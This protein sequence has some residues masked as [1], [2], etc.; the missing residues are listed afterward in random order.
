LLLS[1]I[2]SVNDDKKRAFWLNFVMFNDRPETCLVWKLMLLLG[3]P[4]ISTAHFLYYRFYK[5]LVPLWMRQIPYTM[6]KFA[7][8]EK[9]V[10]LLYKHVVPKPRNQCSKGEQLLVTFAA[11]YIGEAIFA[12]KW[13]VLVWSI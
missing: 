2:F 6:M 12:G 8:F 13:V 9:T 11:G 7:C 10:E 5:G 3:E 1:N 4:E